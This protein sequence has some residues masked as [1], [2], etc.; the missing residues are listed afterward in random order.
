MPAGATKFGSE[1]LVNSITTNFQG[2]ADVVGLTDGRFVAV[3]IDR[4]NGDTFDVRAQMFNADGTKAG[5]EFL[6]NSTTTDN[7]S[8]PAV[9]AL[10]DGGF[11]VAFVDNSAVN[12]DIRVRIFNADGTPRGNDFI[13]T[14]LFPLESQT[15]PDVTVLTNGNF[16]VT[17][18]LLSPGNDVH[19]QIFDSN[20]QL[21]GGEISITASPG[22]A[23][24]TPAIAAL[25]GG[26]FAIA[27][28]VFLMTRRTSEFSSS[29]QPVIQLVQPSK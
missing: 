20:G 16:I 17:W 15:A 4:S 28:E 1:F 19:A 24:Q 12:D 9:A 3:W 21:I 26:G 7:Q 29:M 22:S 5:A 25:A 11:V 10:P 23:D 8:S 2:N 13:A 27:W 14:T 6:I 18:N